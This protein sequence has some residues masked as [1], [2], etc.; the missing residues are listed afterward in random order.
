M[1]SVGD[2]PAVDAAAIVTTVDSNTA[3]TSSVD[4]GDSSSSSPPPV[5]DEKKREIPELA[6]T[7]VDPL[8]EFEARL[9]RLEALLTKASEPDP[10]IA[11]LEAALA[12]RVEPP[13]GYDIADEK[14]TV[15]EHVAAFE[16]KIE[17]AS[18]P[19]SPRKMFSHPMWAGMKGIKGMNAG[20]LHAPNMDFKI[21]NVDINIDG[22]F[23]RA[24]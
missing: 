1:D 17:P 10:R 18:S 6:G 5:S 4:H 2:A 9:A 22:Y 13:S 8:N 23:V 12:R 11:R 7:S 15:R 20:D 19:A 16:D 24:V 3:I 14:T 21:P